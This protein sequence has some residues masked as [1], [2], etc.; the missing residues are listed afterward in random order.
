MFLVW[1]TSGLMRLSLFLLTFALA[2][3]LLVVAGPVS[4]ATVGERTA[5]RIL[6]DVPRP[7]DAWYIAPKTKERY[8][9]GAT[10]DAYAT[11]VQM[12][13][14]VSG[15]NLAKIP[16]SD[17]RERGSAKL[18]KRL[19]GHF[20]MDMSNRGKL[21]YVSPRTLR[22]KALDE[23]VHPINSL[24]RFGFKTSQAELRQIPVAATSLPGP[25]IP[26]RVTTVK[27]ARV[28]TNRGTFT[29]N[30]I[31][32]D[33][34]NPHWQIMTDTGD[35]ADCTVSC[36]A[37]PVR[38]YVQ[39]RN[40][41]AGV[42]GTYFCDDGVNCI[43]ALNSYAYPVLNSWSRVML[44]QA[45]VKYTVEPMVLFDAKNTPLYL[46]VG[47]RFDTLEEFEERYAMTVQTAITNGPA[48]LE[49][50]VS[51]LQNSTMDASQRNV[52]ATR[53]MLGWKGFLVYLVVVRSATL[54]E[55][56]A[57]ATSMGLEYALNLDGGGS[58]ALY[59]DG[60]FY[61]GPGRAV[62]NA[63]LVVQR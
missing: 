25:A 23:G 47:S 6:I 58:T 59:N 52:R 28:A 31:I 15:T 49:G 33:R 3:G 44:N 40:A 51:V 20:V 18:R 13:V 11:I 1:Y 50:G 4:A 27:T 39:R 26:P 63:L 24:L 19:A 35:G 55:T 57:V 17:S 56:V 62:P 30:Q 37:F 21:W 16:I 14:R 61:A 46:P 34:R 48:L 10:V 60:M 42:Q 29:T 54:P 12:A 22:R 7:G 5:G 32:L 9:L 41:I 53:A 36:T 8:Y 43:G 2:M 45:R 38:E